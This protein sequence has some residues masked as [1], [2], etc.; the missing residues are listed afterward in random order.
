MS[1]A[2]ALVGAGVKSTASITLASAS[3]GSITAYGYSD[4]VFAV[5]N[6]FSGTFGSI[7]SPST[8]KGQSIGA[9]FQVSGGGNF[10]IAI[11]G[12]LSTTFLTSVVIQTASG[13][14][15]L[16]LGPGSVSGSYTVW[17]SPISALW[18]I[19]D[20]PSIKQVILQG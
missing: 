20:V 19:G 9:I 13:M 7:G 17:L 10:R 11:F 3:N 14:N 1:G 6:G 18:G 15:Y 16:G 8:F 12:S 5:A 2:L 4:A